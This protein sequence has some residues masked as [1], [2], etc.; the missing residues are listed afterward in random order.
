M[1]KSPKGK[2]TRRDVAARAGVSVATVSY[3]LSGRPGVKIS[4]KTREAVLESA[5]ALDYHP[6]Y[7]GTAL[8]TRRSRNIGVL[9]KTLHHLNYHFYR[10]ILIGAGTRM[11]EENYQLLLFFRTA[12]LRLADTLSS[13]R[14]DGIFVIQSDNEEE[15]IVEL[16]ERGVPMVL[17]NHR[18]PAMPSRM[19]AEVMPDHQGMMEG[20]VGAFAAAG[21]RKI[22]L[23]S[24]ATWANSA[25]NTAFFCACARRSAEGL[26]ASR[27]NRG[28]LPEFA[29]QFRKLIGGK[30]RPEAVFF[31]RFEYAQ[32]ACGILA[33][34]GL[35]P[36][37]DMLLA[38]CTPEEAP[39]SFG[40]PLTLYRY[41][42]MTM[43]ETAWALMKKIFAG[44]NEP[45]EK[46]KVPF[47]KSV[48]P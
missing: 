42:G 40:F 11:E 41:D 4:G 47:V 9:F 10:E 39:E 27:L 30:D 32:T 38:A 33:E 34:K 22:M 14:A 29:E 2:A 26:T 12:G 8:T 25:L 45:L 3:V 6:S 43:G 18:A 44:T 1:R 35:V 13:G 17:I 21:K 36:G 15:P 46:R 23:V 19:A 5:R 20:A 48:F 31:N 28:T 7:I 16:A 37:K 24:P